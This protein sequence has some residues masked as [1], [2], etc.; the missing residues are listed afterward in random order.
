MNLIVRLFLA[1][2]FLQSTIS[3]S[4]RDTTKLRLGG[5]RFLIIP[6]SKDVNPSPKQLYKWN[7]LVWMGVDIG[8]TGFTSLPGYKAQPQGD[9]SFMKTNIPRSIRIGLNVWEAKFRLNK[10]RTANVLVGMGFDWNDYSFEDKIILRETDDIGP[11]SPGQAGLTNINTGNVEVLRS[12]LQTTYFNIPL[13]LNFRTRRTYEHKK[14]FNI[15]LG[16]VGGLRIAS[17]FRHS[18]TQDGDRV[19]DI[20]KD[21]FLLRRFKLDAEVRFRWYVISAFGRVALTE[22][23]N[24]QGPTLFPWSAGIHIQPF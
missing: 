18:F 14:Q 17:N 12:R 19:K 21:D 16:V 20:R 13:M 2:L 3:F 10:K 6:P 22:S 5:T 1:I 11:I 15:T 23:F 24:N 8:L 9:Y 7:N 4:Q